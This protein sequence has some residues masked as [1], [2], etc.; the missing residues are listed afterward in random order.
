MTDHTARAIRAAG[1]LAAACAACAGCSLLQS[2]AASPAPARHPAHATAPA[3][4]PAAASPGLA[5]ILP[6]S[7]SRL[8]AAAALA[9][10]VRRRLRHLVLAAATGRLAGRAAPHGQQRA[11]R[12]PGPG[13]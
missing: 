7:P 12:R 9:G 3:S 10:P 2:P 11:V 8:Q 1:L 4:P 13:R 5:A 6:F